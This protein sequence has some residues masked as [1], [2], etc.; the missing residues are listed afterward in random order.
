MRGRLSPCRGG[1]LA[2]AYR[3][4][5]ARVVEGGKVGGGWLSVVFILP[6]E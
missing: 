5:A 1:C 4:M 2:F 3:A 6:Y